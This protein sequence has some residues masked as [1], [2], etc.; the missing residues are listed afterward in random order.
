MTY[1]NVLLSFECMAIR[2]FFTRVI[3][4]LFWQEDEEEQQNAISV[5]W[6]SSPTVNRVTCWWRPSPKGRLIYSLF[7][8]LP[9]S[10]HLSLSTVWLSLRLKVILCFVG[11]TAVFDGQY[12][13][14]YGVSA[15]T[16][17]RS[18]LFLHIFV[19][20]VRQSKWKACLPVCV[21]DLWHFQWPHWQWSIIT[22]QLP[23]PLSIVCCGEGISSLIT[24]RQR[25]AC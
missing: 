4:F 22:R 8:L 6:Y 16:L 14:D 2:V 11:N 12:R 17:H 3:L 15:L 24:A 13:Y 5:W 25:Y 9:D 19:W 18:P 1:G 23:A 10:W 7:H 20:K 21:F